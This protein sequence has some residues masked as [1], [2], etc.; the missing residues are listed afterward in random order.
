[1][2]GMRDGSGAGERGGEYANRPYRDD[3]GG[4]GQESEECVIGAKLHGIFLSAGW[5]VRKPEN[6]AGRSQFQPSRRMKFPLFATFSFRSPL[7]ETEI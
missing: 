5:L 2:R 7:P 3:D 4:N 1:M 6:R